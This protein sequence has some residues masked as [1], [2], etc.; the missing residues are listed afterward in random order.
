MKKLTT[1]LLL[2][3]VTA[4]MVFALPVSFKA[5]AD[6]ETGDLLLEGADFELT[7]DTGVEATFG[8]T[9]F[10]ASVELNSIVMPDFSLETVTG[11][12]VY[13]F[14]KF[15]VDFE[16]SNENVFDINDDT[17]EDL[18]GVV[19]LDATWKFLNGGAEFYYTPE[20]AFDVY[21][22]PVYSMEL[23]PGT[24]DLSATAYLLIHPDF[25]LGDI[26]GEAKYTMAFDAL[27]VYAGVLPVLYENFEEDRE[28][29]LSIE[30]GVSYAF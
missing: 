30:F 6:A 8:E 1:L 4:T 24:L 3:V 15:D 20:T 26:E 18:T 21:A 27:E 25:K 10:S 9:G 19:A 17:E 12:I 7:L 2:L 22:G 29:A 13:A 23:G 11:E 28:L 14:N 5:Y 16:I